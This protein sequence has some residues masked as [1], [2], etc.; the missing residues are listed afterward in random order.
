LT[1]DRIEI[2]A[3]S[4]HKVIKWIPKGDGE[5]ATRI[6]QGMIASSARAKPAAPVTQQ[7]TPPPPSQPVQQVSVVVPVVTPQQP[8]QQQPQITI[9]RC[10]NC[11]ASLQ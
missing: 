7:P 2:T 8:Q 10:P 11:G 9:T 5:P 1:A 4:D 3:A 6:I